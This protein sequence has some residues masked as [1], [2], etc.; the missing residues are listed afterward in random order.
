[1]GD[2]AISEVPIIVTDCRTLST[3]F[4]L[5]ILLFVFLWNSVLL[6]VFVTVI[7]LNFRDNVVI[8]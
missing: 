8:V 5:R 3:F 7:F 4:V 2:D 1:M 6:S